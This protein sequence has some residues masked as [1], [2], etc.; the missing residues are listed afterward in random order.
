MRR[1]KDE[2]FQELKLSPMFQSVF[3]FLATCIFFHGSCNNC[4]GHDVFFLFL[5]PG[6]YVSFVAS[7]AQEKHENGPEWID[8]SVRKGNHV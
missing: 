7:L 4:F 5:G 2:L 8:Q 3:Y 1:K 6:G